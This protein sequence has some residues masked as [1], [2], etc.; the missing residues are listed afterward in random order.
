MIMSSANRD[1][2]T[3]TFLI[4][5]F[6]FFSSLIALARTSRTILNRSCDVGI[7]DLYFYESGAKSTGGQGCSDTAARTTIGWPATQVEPI[8]SMYPSSIL[9]S[10]RFL[11]PGSQSFH[12]MIPKGIFF[13]WKAVKSLKDI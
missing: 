9:D 11:Q 7:L 6:F 10:T 2:F 8:F 5:V 13:S 4:G 3:S 1:N 12:K